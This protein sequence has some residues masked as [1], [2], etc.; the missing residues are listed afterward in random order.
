MSKSLEQILAKQQEA[1]K[2]AQASLVI[3]QRTNA[4]AE[5]GLKQIEKLAKAVEKQR[6][7]IQVGSS[8]NP[9]QIRL[10]TAQ[11]M[12]KCSPL[13]ALRSFHLPLCSHLSSLFALLYPQFL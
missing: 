8:H 1:L 9:C 10:I 2:A 12:I 4:L 5:A 3:Q 7:S 6:E 13:F 11:V